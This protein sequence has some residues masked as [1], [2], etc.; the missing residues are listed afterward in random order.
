MVV[1]HLLQIGADRK[2]RRGH[3]NDIAAQIVTDISLSKD[4]FCQ[5]FRAT[6]GIGL[7]DSFKHQLVKLR[8]L[9]P[10]VRFAP[11]HIV[12]PGYTTPPKAIGTSSSIVFT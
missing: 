12:P 3:V 6:T 5:A 11:N 10:F 8:S 2:K 1:R 9:Q 7:L 4:V